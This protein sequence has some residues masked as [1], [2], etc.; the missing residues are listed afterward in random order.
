MIKELKALDIEIEKL[1]LSEYETLPIYDGIVD[2]ES[3]QK[4]N[5]K[6][7]W[8]LKEVNSAGDEGGWDMR[9]AIKKFKVKNGLKAVW[10]KTFSSIVYVSEGIINNKNWDDIPD[11]PDNP[12]VVDI[13]NSI[14]YINMKKIAGKPRA[15][16]NELSHAYQTY[17][18]LLFKQIRLIDADIIIFGGTY[19]YFKNDIPPHNLKKSGTCNVFKVDDKIFVDAYHPQYF[20]VK[21]KDYFTDILSG[22]KSEF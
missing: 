14:A 4:T 17:K 12:D 22:I 18:E 10:A 2:L 3:Y 19:P 20:G 21:R 7:L 11:I 9:E 6:V 8:I 13:L 15:I 1:S 16:S 5:T